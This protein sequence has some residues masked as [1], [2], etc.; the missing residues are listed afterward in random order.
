MAYAACPYYSPCVHWNLVVPQSSP[1]VYCY[2]VP[3]TWTCVSS[4]PKCCCVGCCCCCCRC[5]SSAAAPAQAEA[6]PAV[7]FPPRSGTVQ[8]EGQVQ[9]KPQ[10]TSKVA[11]SS[12]KKS[13]DDTGKGWRRVS[14]LP[15]MRAEKEASEYSTS[16]SSYSR[17]SRRRERDHGSRRRPS[18]DSRGRCEGVL[19]IKGLPRM[20][21]GDDR[22]RRS[23]SSRER[24]CT[25]KGTLRFN[26]E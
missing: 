21:R 6:S 18:P 25:L 23:E 8:L 15:R 20:D 10:D 5:S 22:R 12:R 17:D 14:S 7:A 19:I 3:T 4:V 2:Y 26:A 11:E 9:I 16:S 24:G 13:A 1:Q